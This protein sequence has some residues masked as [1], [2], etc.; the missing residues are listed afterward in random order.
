MELVVR[1]KYASDYP[2]RMEISNQTQEIFPLSSYYRR[3]ISRAQEP[4]IFK[5]MIRNHRLVSESRLY[6]NSLDHATGRLDSIW[7]KKVQ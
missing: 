3:T 5:A 1:N 2:N 7:R 6:M 4:G